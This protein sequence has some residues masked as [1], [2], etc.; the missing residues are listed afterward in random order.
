MLKKYKSF[1]SSFRSKERSTLLP[2]AHEKGD[3]YRERYKLVKQRLLRNEN[4]CP[5]NMSN[6]SNS[7]II[8]VINGFKS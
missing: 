8:K 2:E 6:S 7:D 1:N 5:P 3:M 4:F